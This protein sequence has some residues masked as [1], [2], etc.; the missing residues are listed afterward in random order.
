MSAALPAGL[1]ERLRVARPFLLTAL[2]ASL[3]AGLVAAAIAHAPTRPLVWMVAYLILVAGVAQGV[4][5]LGQ[6]LLPPRPPAARRC[7]MEWLLFNGGNA[8][9]I[10]GTLLASP[11]LVALGTALFVA[12]L[13]AFL[14]G[15]RGAGGGWLLQLFRA[16]L[17][18]TGLGACVGL[19]LTLAGLA[20]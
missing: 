19:A 8:G 1:R 15:V 4:L 2:A 14:L 11:A 18:V 5:G 12:A 7:I 9:V 3:G 10:A 20:R 13:A 6:A 16:M 17:M